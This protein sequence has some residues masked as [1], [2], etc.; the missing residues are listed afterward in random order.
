MVGENA[1]SS[2]GESRERGE[3]WAYG[4]KRRTSLRLQPR[5]RDSFRGAIG[6]GDIGMEKG[7]EKRAGEI[8]V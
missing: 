3:T 7:E 5:E 4:V 6:G 1:K 8:E 2:V